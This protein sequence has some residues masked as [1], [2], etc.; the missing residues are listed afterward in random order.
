M[1]RKRN[2][3]ALASSESSS[4]GHIPFLVTLPI[5]LSKNLNAGS[6][7][8]R[9]GPISA[10][11][12]NKARMMAKMDTAQK[13]EQDNPP[14]EGPGT[15]EYDNSDEEA[16]DEPGNSQNTTAVYINH[17]LCT[18]RPEQ[19]K[20]LSSTNDQITVVVAN[21]ETISHIGSYG[22]TVLKGA[23]SVNGAYFKANHTDRPHAE[24]NVC[25]VFAPSTH[26]IY[27]IKGLEY[28]NE[29]QFLNCSNMSSLGRL[30]AL[31][32]GI[33]NVKLDGEQHR[34]FA[35][36]T[37]SKADPLNR[38]LTTDCDSYDWYAQLSNAVNHSSATMVSG[39]PSAGKSTF[40]RRLL[41][42]YLTGDGKKPISPSVYYLDL[43]PDKPEY[44]PH[45]QIS[46]VLV[47]EV[48]FGP[49]FTHPAPLPNPQSEKMNKLIRA[50]PMPYNGF[51]DYQ[52]YFLSCVD[53]LFQAYM[54]IQGENSIKRTPL[55]I[56]TPGFTYLSNIDV[57]HQTVSRM[58][59]QHLIY[60]G[61]LHPSQE[62]HLSALA[63]VKQA[64]TIAGASVY[65]I[66][67]YIN[68]SPPSH[69]D[70]EL[71][72]MQM[73]SY[74]HCTGL[75]NTELPQRTYKA[76]PLSFM[77]P[78]EIHYEESET[79]RQGFIGFLMLCEWLEPKY[80]LTALNGALVQI[81]ET[82]DEYIQQQYGKLPR[83]NKFRIPYFEKGP[84]NSVEPLNPKTSR[85]VCTTM[86]QSFK[87]QEQIVQLLVPKTHE[88]L[89][90][91]L[92]P[93]KTVFVFG[94]CDHPEWAYIED[95]YY[96]LW[97]RK[98]D[99]EMWMENREEGEDT[100]AFGWMDTGVSPED[101]ALPPWVITDAKMQEI[102]AL[103]T[104]RRTRKFQN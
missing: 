62:V 21:N 57:L 1:T 87:P 43:D 20:I 69:T 42:R 31:Y 29:I 93:E 35:L 47:K 37:E 90:Y 22:F 23:V 30:S 7:D 34:T 64:A 5:S 80:L 63:A 50:H 77:P 99:R 10:V 33:W 24:V 2:R 28:S 6:E 55:I 16:V 25:R 91:S 3:S 27:A 66:S 75:T 100:A 44:T 14:S 46:L 95:P 68:S 98:K 92:K 58:K 88:H 39:A 32:S 9:A 17:I 60:M 41:N 96:D 67:A 26:P 97:D 59:I 56:N 84:S 76:K 78:W 18:W 48:N 61:T 71:R 36:A 82:E 85:L 102:G 52:E 94:C 11:A 53:D 15:A 74:F 38:P 45:G 13:G 70:S 73:L 101:I 65:V 83:T 81:V 40:A 19:T 51:E 12:A 8:G 79:A 104:V 49:S 89:L 86:I 72:S 103:N 54:A 4:S